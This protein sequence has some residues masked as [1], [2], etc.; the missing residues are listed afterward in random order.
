[1]RSTARR[2]APKSS[3][4]SARCSSKLP[5]KASSLSSSVG[6]YLTL[7]ADVIAETAFTTFW[8]RYYIP[9]EA[10]LASYYEEEN[11]DVPITESANVKPFF[12]KA[13]ELGLD[14]AIGYG[15]QTRTIRYNAASYISKDGKPLNKYRKVGLDG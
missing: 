5:S 1:M 12:D 9:D 2:H 6:A 4:G 14:V 15:E 13:K 7:T 10:E 8:P 11:E 3:T